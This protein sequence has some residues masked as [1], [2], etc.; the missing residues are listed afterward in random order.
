MR[1]SSLEA[2]VASSHPELG[3][4]ERAR[5]VGCPNRVVIFSA[6]ARNKRFG[7][8]EFFGRAHPSCLSP[9]FSPAVLHEVRSCFTAKGPH[10]HAAIVVDRVFL[11]PDRVRRHVPAIYLE[12]SCDS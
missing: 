5:L 10:G 12:A 4:P 2:R 1:R 7:C 6:A 8:S 11:W 9:L 3:T